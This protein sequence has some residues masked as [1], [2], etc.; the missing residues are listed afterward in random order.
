[1]LETWLPLT[2]KVGATKKSSIISLDLFNPNCGLAIRIQKE[3]AQL[4]K[5]TEGINFT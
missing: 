4:L 3:Q 5:A 1:M 2:L